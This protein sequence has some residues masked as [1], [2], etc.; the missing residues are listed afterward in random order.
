MRVVSYDGRTALVEIYLASGLVSGV[1]VQKL[2]ERFEFML[3]EMSS[4]ANMFLKKVFK[5]GDYYAL[6]AIEVDE[7]EGAVRLARR[8]ERRTRKI[9][10]HLR[11]SVMSAI[12]LLR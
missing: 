2:I 9:G 7:L 3:A 1:A 6:V 5:K 10:A 12:N 11:D 4:E 8:V